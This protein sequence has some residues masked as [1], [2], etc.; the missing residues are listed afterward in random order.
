MAM[1]KASKAPKRRPRNKW[2]DYEAFKQGLQC[3]NLTPAEY[4]KQIKQ[5]LK[6]KRL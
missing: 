6:R 2:L 5:Y 4:D 1:G 3:K